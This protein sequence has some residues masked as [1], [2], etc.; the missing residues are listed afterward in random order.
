MPKETSVYDQGGGYV[1][2]EPLTEVSRELIPP[3]K[4]SRQQHDYVIPEDEEYTVFYGKTLATFTLG[5]SRGSWRR[6]SLTNAGEAPLIIMAGQNDK[7][8]GRQFQ[9][10]RPGE[11]MTVLDQ[12]EAYWSVI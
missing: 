5:R 2:Q 11:S 3:P 7:V 9:K 1:G 8:L 4:T 12:A 10:V 6:H